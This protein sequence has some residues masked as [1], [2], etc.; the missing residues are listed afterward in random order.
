MLA[1]AA[2]EVVELARVLVVCCCWGEVSVEM[3][4]MSSFTISCSESLAVVV[5]AK[6]APDEVG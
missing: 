3:E 5:T 4:V 2:A 6:W 1:A